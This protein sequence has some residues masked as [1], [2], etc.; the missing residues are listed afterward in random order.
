MKM[1]GFKA[2]PAL[3]LLFLL[4]VPLLAGCG[5][6][7]GREDAAET[8]ET[9]EDGA[10]DES[11]PPADAGSDSSSPQADGAIPSKSQEALVQAKS[12]GKPILLCFRSQTCAPCIQMGENIEQVIPGYQDRATFII[13]NVYDRSEESLCMEYG[14]QTIPTT[15]FIKRDGRVLGGYE[16][17]MEPDAIRQQLESLLASQ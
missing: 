1:K 5:S 16:G 3:L 2:V 7:N 10:S 12:E 15:L 4:L 6:G 13:V 11:V 17:V 8:V 14:I 9:A